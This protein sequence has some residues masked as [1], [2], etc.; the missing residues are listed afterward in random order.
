[1]FTGTYFF[2]FKKMGG[3]SVDRNEHV[4]IVVVRGSF[5]LSYDSIDIMQ[6]EHYIDN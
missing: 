3:T 5:F 6:I 4:G 1:M 2:G